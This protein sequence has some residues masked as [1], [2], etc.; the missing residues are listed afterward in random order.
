M[1]YTLEETHVILFEPATTLNTGN[2]KY[3]RTVADLQK[4]MTKRQSG[5]SASRKHVA[6]ITWSGLPQGWKASNCCCLTGGGR[7]DAELV[8]W[9]DGMRLRAI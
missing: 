3:E 5:R 2:I 4:N 7:V 6:L 1:P 9:S 8:N